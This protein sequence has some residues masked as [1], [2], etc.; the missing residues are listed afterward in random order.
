MIEYDIITRY[1]KLNIKVYLNIINE[2][3]TKYKIQNT[4]YKMW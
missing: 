2:Y 1:Y 3:Y 4:K